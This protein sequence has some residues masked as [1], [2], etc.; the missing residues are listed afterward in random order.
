MF[1]M[2]VSICLPLIVILQL[3]ILWEQAVIRSD[4][5][6]I[7]K[8]SFVTFLENSPLPLPRFARRAA[9]E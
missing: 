1:E 9:N 4:Q 8:H 7:F 3:V 2:I 5:N 6:F